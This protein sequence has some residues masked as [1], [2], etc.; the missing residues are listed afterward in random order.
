MSCKPLSHQYFKS[1]K[2]AT[3][4]AIGALSKYPM[5]MW[6][7]LPHTICDRFQMDFHR[8]KFIS[9]NG[10][11]TR[12]HAISEKKNNRN[13]HFTTYLDGRLRDVRFV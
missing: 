10:V 6:H 4:N 13:L 9:N 12:A 2:T 7:R 8:I 5:K 1:V 11:D 3:R